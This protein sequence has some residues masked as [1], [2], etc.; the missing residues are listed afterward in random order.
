MRSADDAKDLVQ[1]VFVSLWV[2]RETLVVSTSLSGYLFAAIR[3][4][5]VN[6]IEANIV[7]ED[8]LDL[9]G[10]AA[11]EYDNTT[12]EQI[13]VY[14]METRLQEGIRRLSPKTREVF[15]LSR[16]DEL[17]I[18]EIADK[19]HLSH[20]TVKNQITTALKSLRVHI[21]SDSEKIKSSSSG[22]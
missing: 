3:Y 21:Y 15:E 14:D 17:S 2:K 7:R 1:D 22:Q 18:S 8:Y 20:Q 10:K 19:L 11:S 12:R 4:K 16:R 6:Y 13:A 5:I 9:L